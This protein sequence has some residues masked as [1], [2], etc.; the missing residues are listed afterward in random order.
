[1]HD[2]MTAVGALAFII[3]IVAIGFSGN[4]RTQ[5]PAVFFILGAALVLGGTGVELASLISVGSAM[6]EG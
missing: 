6:S 2:Y 5:F 1:M 4:R 3:G